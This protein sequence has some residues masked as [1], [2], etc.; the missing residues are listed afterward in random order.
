MLVN[1]YKLFLTKKLLDKFVNFF[2]K[3]MKMEINERIN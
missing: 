2:K 3:K 1:Y